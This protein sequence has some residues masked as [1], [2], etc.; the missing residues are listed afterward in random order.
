MSKRKHDEISVDTSTSASTGHADGGGQDDET[1]RAA[2]RARVVQGLIDSKQL[3]AT[4]PILIETVSMSDLVLLLRAL[5]E[6][7]EQL[8]KAK[9]EAE[10]KVVTFAHV[11][12]AVPSA[13]RDACRKLLSAVGYDPL[14]ALRVS[15]V[16]ALDVV[17]TLADQPDLVQRVLLF[18]Q[19]V[20]F[21]GAQRQA[22]TA[23]T[24]TTSA[25]AGTGT[26]T[27]TG[28]GDSNGSSSST[29]A[30]AAAAPDSKS[31][32]LAVGKCDVCNQRAEGKVKHC[33]VC[34]DFDMCLT[35]F[36]LRTDST[37]DA[38]HT[39]TDKELPVVSASDLEMLNAATRT[40]ELI[41][42]ELGKHGLL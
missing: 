21:R 6:R 14:E 36:A 8:V 17:Q 11:E 25:A 30:A 24:A 26:G 16:V 13:L 20:L 22:T 5:S 18:V 12:T 2:K 34:P 37:H 4:G 38:A 10:I 9:G 23:M 7:L 3:P 39:W 42:Q 35:C 28:S 31:V 41:R 1:S 32:I 29:T 15:P 33:A 27:G 40:N 19:M